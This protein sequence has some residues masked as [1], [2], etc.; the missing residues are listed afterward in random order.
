[1]K[2]LKK[3]VI[4]VYNKTKTTLTECEAMENLCPLP[5]CAPSTT[6]YGRSFHG[7][8]FSTL[9]TFFV[10]PTVQLESTLAFTEATAL[11][12]S[13][14]NNPPNNIISPPNIT[15]DE[16]TDKISKP[17]DIPYPVGHPGNYRSLNLV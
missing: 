5:L 13:H 12:E 17:I 1:M 3:L 16:V 9:Y 6:L 2:S 11:H 10:E 14:A 4:S 8:V 7:S 15:R